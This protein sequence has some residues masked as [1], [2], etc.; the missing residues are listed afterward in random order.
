M[1]KRCLKKTVGKACLNFS[2]LQFLLS[3]IELILNSRSL[4]KLCDD[5]TSNILMPNPLLFGFEHSYNEFEIDMKKRVK[6]VE[7]TV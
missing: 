5:D 2:E 3:E 7:N 6:Y 1:V 4:K